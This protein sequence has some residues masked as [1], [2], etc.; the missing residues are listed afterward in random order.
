MPAQGSS[1][2]RRRHQAARPG[3]SRIAIGGSCRD[4]R[5]RPATAPAPRLPAPSRSGQQPA[6]SLGSRSLA[7]NAK[8]HMASGGHDDAKVR[9]RRND[10]GRTRYRPRCAC[11][12]SVACPLR[13][14]GSR[15]ARCHEGSARPQRSPPTLYRRGTHPRSSRRAP[16]SGGGLVQARCHDGRRAPQR[17]AIRGTGR[18]P[19]RSATRVLPDGSRRAANNAKSLI[20]RAEHDAAT[21]GAQRNDPAYAY[22][23]GAHAVHQ[24][25]C[26]AG[27]RI[28]AS[29]MPR[30]SAASRNEARP[31]RR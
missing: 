30:R 31:S 28:A 19:T 2:P 4:G 6:C 3:G 24:A 29:T 17:R 22:R 13:D 16:P 8:S 23:C 7:N 15:R 11:G 26:P 1:G 27:S 25:A 18:V 14:R 5:P 20:G 21:V 12:S 10:A 9:A